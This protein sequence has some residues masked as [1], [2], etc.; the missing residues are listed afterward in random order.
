MIGPD[1]ILG[2]ILILT[3]DFTGHAG[4]EVLKGS[5]TGGTLNYVV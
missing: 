4:T 1:K 2:L 5:F 3:S